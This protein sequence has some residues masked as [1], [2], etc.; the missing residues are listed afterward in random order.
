VGE[1]MKSGKKGDAQKGQ[2]LYAQLAPQINDFIA[3]QGQERFDV[4]RESNGLTLAD[5]DKA[6]SSER[7]QK[8]DFSGIEKT[9]K[10]S[11]IS[12]SARYDSMQALNAAK[13]DPAALNEFVRVINENFTGRNEKKGQDMINAV[14]PFIPKDTGPTLDQINKSLQS[15]RESPFGSDD[16]KQVV[17]EAIKKFQATLQNPKSSG[18]EVQKSRD[19]VKAA[20]ADYLGD[21]DKAG[22]YASAY[23]KNFKPK[24]TDDS[25]PTVKALTESRNALTDNMNTAA[26]ALKNLADDINNSKGGKKITSSIDLMN[27][28]VE[29]ASA[30]II[31]F[32]ELTTKL[33]TI[34][35]MVSD[36]IGP[37]EAKVA[38]LP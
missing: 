24:V 15:Q 30:G 20:L 3:T 17:N 9:I 4:L 38:R 6:V 19:A 25:D 35:K 8:V 21:Q 29:K 2:D 36:R 31:S 7:F 5:R 13:K 32:S 16:S 11:S 10:E 33:E 34:S 22:Q 28:A 18:D 37:L 14:K 27:D 12:D 23:E 1:L 26:I